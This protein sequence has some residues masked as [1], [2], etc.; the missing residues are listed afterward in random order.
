MAAITAMI[1][2]TIINSIR[3]KPLFLFMPA[4]NGKRR[5]P[6]GAPSCSHVGVKPY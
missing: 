6:A 4:P 3:V 5:G 1:T 2:T